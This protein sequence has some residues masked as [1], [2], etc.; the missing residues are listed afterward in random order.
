MGYKRVL[1]V[2]GLAAAVLIGSVASPALAENLELGPFGGPG[3]T[4]QA[5]EC[6]DGKLMV[7]VRTRPGSFWG[8]T[9][10]DQLKVQ[11]AAVSNGRWAS[12]VDGSGTIGNFDATTV[13]TTRTCPTDRVV[14]GIRGRAGSVVDRL[15]IGCRRVGANGITSGDTL[16]LAAVGGSGG[17]AFEEECGNTG[18]VFAAGRGGWHV[19]QLSMTCD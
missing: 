4:A 5:S 10:V 9:V 1:R 17:T 16:W 3:G 7:G 13:R 8:S 15:Q 12:L 6:R 2:A 11:C 19:D 18:V 14:S